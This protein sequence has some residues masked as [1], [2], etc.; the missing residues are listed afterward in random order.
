MVNISFLRRVKVPLIVLGWGASLASLTLGAIFQGY[1]LPTTGGGLL[2]EV[3][4]ASPLWLWI[5]YLGSFGISALAATMIYD[6]APAIIG[7][8][9]SYGICAILTFIVLAL[10]EFIGIIQTN[11]VL[12]KVAILHTFSALFPIALLVDMVGSIAGVALGERFLYTS[13]VFSA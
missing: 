8:F 4:G 2:P 3:Y 9:F 12:Q 13:G 11:G 7:F 1:L 10:P 6:P 5:F